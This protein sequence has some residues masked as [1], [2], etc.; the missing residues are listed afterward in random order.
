MVFFKLLP[1]F[2]HIPTLA[3]IMTDSFR[4][5]LFTQ[6]YNIFHILHSSI[7][8]RSCHISPLTC[9]RRWQAGLGSSYP[10]ELRGVVGRR[11]YEADG[12]GSTS[13]KDG[14]AYEGRADLG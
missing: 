8:D 5:N 4:D 13:D 7:I 6:Y 1:S 11:G 10:G 3:F 2:I 14:I 9:F 12:E